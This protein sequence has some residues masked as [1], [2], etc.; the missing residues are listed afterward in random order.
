MTTQAQTENQTNTTETTDS[1]VDMSNLSFS[2]YERVRRGEK[3]ES[4]AQQSA[5]ELK[6]VQEQKKS[7]NS[8]TAETEDEVEDQESEDDQLDTQSKEDGKPKKKGGF[9][10]RIDKLNARYAAEKQRNDELEQRLAQLERSGGEKTPKQPVEAKSQEGKP[11]PDNFDTHAEYVEAL[12]DWKI[13]QREKTRQA[14][15]ERKQLETEHQAKLKSHFDRVKSFAEKMADFEEVIEAADDVVVSATLEELIVSSDHGPELLYELA[16]N[17]DEF[18]RINK[19]SPVACAREL[20]R[21]EAKLTSKSSAEEKKPEPNKITKAPK[22][23]EPVGGGK[24]TVSKSPEDMSFA[25]YERYR[26]DQMK[27]K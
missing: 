26:R 5:P 19:L 6:N 27:R 3:V 18:I 15:A 8:G 9:Q 20:G 13:E 2:D 22:P 24:S 14:E 23:I 16:K 17:K 21:F 1:P 10:R 4:N 25:E 11:N 7:A 12:A